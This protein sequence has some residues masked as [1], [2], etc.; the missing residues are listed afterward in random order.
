M[1]ISSTCK[2]KEC[3]NLIQ[4]KLFQDFFFLFHIFQH[5]TVS[6]SGILFKMNVHFH[7]DVSLKIYSCTQRQKKQFSNK[8]NF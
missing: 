2:D 3:T 8:I 7:K 6:T 5:K 1:E 4:R